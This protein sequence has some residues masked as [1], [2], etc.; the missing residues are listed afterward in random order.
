VPKYASKSPFHYCSVELLIDLTVEN[1]RYFADKRDGSCSLLNVL[2]GRTDAEEAYWF[3]RVAEFDFEGWAVGGSVGGVLDLGRFLRRL[4]VLR[5]LKMLGG[6]KGRLHVLGVGALNWAVALTAIQR[7]IQRSL[8]EGFSVSFDTST[9]FTESAKRDRVYR[10]PILTK[11]LWGLLSGEFPTGYAAAVRDAG[12]P[13]PPGSPLSSVLTLG[14]MNPRKGS[15]EKRTFDAFSLNALI[16][17]NCYVQLA[18]VGAANRAA[19]V[20]GPVPQPLADVLG[21]I[22]DL[23]EREEW[24]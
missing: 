9:P 8:R 22:G 13:F 16:N 6:R 19:F 14:D 5:D 18:A 12:H 20:T 11:D 17:H 1:L 10:A 15:F 21:L 24:A 3:S 23:F 2:H 4:L 7:A